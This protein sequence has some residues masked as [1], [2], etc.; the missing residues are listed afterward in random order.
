MIRTTSDKILEEILNSKHQLFTLITGERGIF[1]IHHQFEK[2]HGKYEV[3]Y[4][5]MI[6]KTLPAD[7]LM[8]RITEQNR[9]YKYNRHKVV[10]LLI[11]RLWDNGHY[12]KTMHPDGGYTKSYEC[13]LL[14]EEN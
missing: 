8:F 6:G 7:T 4:T 10:S 3:D 2:S 11:N 13:I 9:E 12:F 14:D 1:D 5:P